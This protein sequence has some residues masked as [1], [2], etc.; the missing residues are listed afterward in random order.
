MMN[1]LR[2]KKKTSGKIK[3]QA[4]LSVLMKNKKLID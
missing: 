2:Q 3:V 1:N 4:K